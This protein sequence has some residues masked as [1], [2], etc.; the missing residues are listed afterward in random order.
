MHQARIGGYRNP[1][2]ITG[3][4]IGIILTLLA[5]ALIVA[6]VVIVPQWVQGIIEVCEE[7]GIVVQ[8][9]GS[10]ECTLG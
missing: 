1:L 9:P 6:L 2:A 7:Q 8:R 5:I 10:Y 4:V 3:L